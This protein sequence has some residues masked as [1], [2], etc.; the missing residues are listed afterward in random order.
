MNKWN[1]WNKWGQ[2]LTSDIITPEGL[3]LALS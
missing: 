2:I 3:Q 1:K